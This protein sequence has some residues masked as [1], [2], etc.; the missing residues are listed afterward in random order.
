MTKQSAFPYVAVIVATALLAL[1]PYVIGSF[2][3]SFAIATLNF[4]VV[5]TAWGMFC[6]PTRY[7]SLASVVFF[8]AG[9]Y[10]VA[11]LGDY[12]SW[13]LLLLIAAFVGAAIALIVGLATLR[14]EGIYFVIFTFGLSEMIRQ[15]ATW[16]EFNITE[17]VGRYVFLDITQEQ[18]YWQLLV[19]L[20]LLLIGGTVLAR[21]RLGFALRVIGGDEMVARHFGLNP[22]IAKLCL[23]MLSSMVIAVAGAIMAPRWTYIDPAIAFNPT[24]SFQVVIMAL[25]GGMHR[26]YGPLLGALLMSALFEALGSQFPHAFALLLGLVFIVIVYLLPNGIVGRVEQALARVRNGRADASALVEQRS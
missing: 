9:S 17:S 26:I 15:L 18:I 22:T 1:L 13:P 23:F 7:I 10:T 16:Y 11:V 21:S 20:A 4:A 6:G 25:L 19:L 5:A 24:L 3:L 14:L 12:V 8:G 2:G